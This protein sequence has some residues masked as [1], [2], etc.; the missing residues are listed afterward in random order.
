MLVHGFTGNPFSMRLL[1]EQLAA[2]GFTVDVPRLPGHGTHVND[3]RETRYGDWRAE[4]V[5]AAERVGR[6]F[7]RVMLVGLSAGA[8]LALDVAS[9][10][11]QSVAAVVTINGNILDREGFVVKLAPYLEKVMPI[12]PAYLAG[13][14]KDDIAK[15]GVTERAYDSVATAAGNSMLREL[16]RIRAQLAQLKCPILV[17]YSAED[18]TVPP[19]N[20]RAILEL[21]AHAQPIELVL[22]RSYHVATLDYDLELLADRITTLGDSLAS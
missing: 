3:L 21:V 22:E 20:S 19:A 14:R 8:T 12:A 4:V 17:A 9:S 6:R 1:A 11:E 15:P 7:S 18:H 2:R 5:A 10:G 16:P 13:M